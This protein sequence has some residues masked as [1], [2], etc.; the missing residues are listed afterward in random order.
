MIKYLNIYVYIFSNSD[1]VIYTSYT[2]NYTPIVYDMRFFYTEQ[3]HKVD[4]HIKHTDTN[5]PNTFPF[6]LFKPT[7]REDLSFFPS[8]FLLL[9][10]PSSLL[11]SCTFFSSM[12]TAQWPQVPRS[13]HHS[14]N[15]SHL[16]F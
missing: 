1:F 6:Q 16:I 12:D 5:Q 2:Y 15:T 10:S 14:I 8:R 11:A 7:C 9:H 13:L 4:K 3:A